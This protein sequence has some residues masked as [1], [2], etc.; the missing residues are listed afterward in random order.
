[1]NR[2]IR[3]AATLV[4]AALAF[5]GAA[6]APATASAATPGS[7][8]SGP[9]L[10]EPQRKLA[11]AL[12]CH[13]AQSPNGHDPVLLVHGA[14]ATAAEAWDWAWTPALLADGYDV[15]TIDVPDRGLEDN[16]R[17]AE[18]AVHAIRVM[19]ERFASTVDVVGLYQGSLDLRWAARWWPDV[20]TKVDDHVSLDGANRGIAAANL[21]CA[22]GRCVPAV[23]QLSMGSQFLTALNEGDESPGEIDYTS[24]YSRGDA[25]ISPQLPGSVSEIDGAVNVPIDSL[26]PGRFPDHVQVLSDAVAYAATTDTFAQDG[27][28]DPAAFD[29]G[30]CTSLL[31][32]GVTPAEALRREFVIYRTGLPRFAGLTWREI[33]AEPPL[34]CYARAGDCG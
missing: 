3:V 25:A 10:Q 23:W 18:Y 32:S 1:M 16:Q 8:V 22:D 17:A 28:F 11:A 6:F 5:P 2:R 4:S 13:D 15:C 27:P 31:V 21:L 20:L 30:A 7:A 9:A 33:D 24:I 26:C 29:R 12:R 14:T 19:A 34:R